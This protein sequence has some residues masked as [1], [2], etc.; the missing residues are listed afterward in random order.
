LFCGLRD[1]R[2]GIILSEI[3]GPPKAMQ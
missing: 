3:L 1:I 2:R